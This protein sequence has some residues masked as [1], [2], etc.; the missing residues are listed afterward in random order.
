VRR[1]SLPGPDSLDLDFSILKNT[2]ITERLNVQ[3]RA[4]AFNIINKFNEGMP[5]AVL[6]TATTAQILTSQAPVITPRQI[7]FALKFDF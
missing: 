4:E 6:D 7:Q 2:K 5:S 1:N 3:F